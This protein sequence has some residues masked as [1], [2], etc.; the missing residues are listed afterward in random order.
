MLVDPFT[1]RKPPFRKFELNTI[2]SN[3]HLTPTIAKDTLKGPVPDLDS[4]ACHRGIE[5]FPHL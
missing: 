4:H 1:I 2:A 5:H 3:A